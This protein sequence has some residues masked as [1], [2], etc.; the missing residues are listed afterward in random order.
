MILEAV[1]NSV[2]DLVVS[3]QTHGDEDYR[4]YP[5]LIAREGDVE[6]AIRAVRT[7]VYE[8]GGDGE[9]TH[10]SALETALERIDGQQL[11][12]DYRRVL[13]MFVNDDTK[14]ARS[15]RSAAA[16]GSMIREAGI[17]FYIICQPTAKLAELANTAGGLLCQIT[18]APSVELMQAIALQISGS[19]IRSVASGSSL[20]VATARKMPTGSGIVRGRLI[21]QRGAG[22]N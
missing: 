17:L 12:V 13:L 16:L 9:E 21:D 11:Q 18:N 6:E 5:E 4:E 8:G 2:P 14:P 1:S 20:P 7:I 10:L 15:G 22:S 3:V 19:V